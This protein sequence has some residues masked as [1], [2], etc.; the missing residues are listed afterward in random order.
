MLS[1]NTVHLAERDTVTTPLAQLG[2]SHGLSADQLRMYQR[3]YGLGSVQQHKA[4][5]GPMLAPVLSR[6]LASLPPAKRAHGQLFYCKTQTH[7]TLADQNWLRDLADHC[8][9]VG[10]EAS[11]I[12]MTSCASALAL[13][14]FAGL[15][16]TQE[17]LIV[18]TGEKAFHPSVSR[19]PVGLLAEVPA[20][21]VLNSGGGGWH[22]A[23][24]SLRHL[25]AFYQNA[26]AM[27]PDQRRDLQ[28]C[29][30][31]ALRDFMQASLDEYAPQLRDDFVFLPHNLNQPVSNLLIRHFGWQDRVLQG[32]V[33][34][35]GHAY[36]ADIFLNLRAFETSPRRAQNQLLVL[37]AGTGVTFATCLLERRNSDQ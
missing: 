4:D 19:L 34:H 36:C 15:A 10:W 7:N 16:R 30:V 31:D 14:H 32:D 13:I 5:L 20:A 11:A 21:A 35:T 27:T 25:P 22:V 9:M 1:L 28:A 18:L 2:A 37:A 29:Y 24:T 33:Q 23:G 12:T 8:G 26:D 6:A 3:F 17:P